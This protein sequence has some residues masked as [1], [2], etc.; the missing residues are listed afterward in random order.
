MAS[1]S[2]RSPLQRF[3][4][5]GAPDK[6][7][8]NGS[9]RS[10]GRWMAAIRMLTAQLDTSS[11][12][13]TRVVEMTGCSEFPKSSLHE[14]TGSGAN[15]VLMMCASLRHMGQPVNC[16]NS[17]RSAPCARCFDLYSAQSIAHR[18][19]SYEGQGAIY[20]L[21]LIGRRAARQWVGEPQTYGSVIPK[22]AR[23]RVSSD[24]MISASS[25]LMWS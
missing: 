18:V 9:N 24:S 21:S 17:R 4:L 12:V 19:R 25:S 20:S 6:L 15:A 3:S 8:S 2:L 7:E 14:M 16:L 23:M 11:T 5:S 22:P 10:W 13:E 1:T